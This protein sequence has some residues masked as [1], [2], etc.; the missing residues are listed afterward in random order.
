MKNYRLL[1]FI[2]ALWMLSSVQP[3]F[4]A[5]AN[6]DLANRNSYRYQLTFTTAS[7]GEHHID[8]IGW[9]HEVAS[10]RDAASGLPTGKRQHKPFTVI[11]ETDRSTPILANLL[12]KNESITSWE[13][14]CWKPGRN[15]KRFQLYKTV[16]LTNPVVVGVANE[17]ALENRTHGYELEKLEFTYEHIKWYYHESDVTVEDDWQGLES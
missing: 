7:S 15:G 1:C 9:N 5:G 11:K 8:I 2:S 17:S 14:R 12:L 10:P 16:T 13:L 6:S 4:A 3:V